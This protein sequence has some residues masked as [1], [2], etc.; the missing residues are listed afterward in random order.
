LRDVRRGEV[1]NGPARIPIPFLLGI[2]RHCK[3]NHAR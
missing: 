2:H 3:V 1:F